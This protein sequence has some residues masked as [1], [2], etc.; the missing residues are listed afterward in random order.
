ML[1]WWKT[2]QI[3]QYTG[4]SNVL[5]DCRLIKYSLLGGG[6]LGE[7]SPLSPHHIAHSEIIPEHRNTNMNLRIFSKVILTFLVMKISKNFKTI[8]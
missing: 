3:H 1:N 4:F 2:R 8:F 6:G 5:M 7:D